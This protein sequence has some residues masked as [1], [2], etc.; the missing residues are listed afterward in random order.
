M[1]VDNNVGVYAYAPSYS[2]SYAQVDQ[3]GGGNQPQAGTNIQPRTGGGGNQLQ[4][5]PQPG[6]EAQS[7]AEGGGTGR[8]EGIF[9]VINQIGNRVVTD[10]PLPNP[11]PS[12]KPNNV[13]YNEINGPRPPSS[14]NTQD[15]QNGGSITPQGQDPNHTVSNDR[16]LVS[17]DPQYGNQHDGLLTPG[18]ANSPQADGPG[19]LYGPDGKPLSTTSNPSYDPIFTNNPKPVVEFQRRP[20]IVQPVYDVRYINNPIVLNNNSGNY[21]TGYAPIKTDPWPTPINSQYTP[22]QQALI[23]VFEN[24]HKNKNYY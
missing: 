9:D 15:G 17:G 13:I 23:Q 10:L 20:Y 6:S 8:S 11:P 21:G 12:I 24:A 2:Q 14:N 4:S 5:Q 1:A 7:R 22:E 16:L 18:G 3:Q 19:Q